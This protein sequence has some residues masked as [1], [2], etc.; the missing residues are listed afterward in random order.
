MPRVA[1]I[2]LLPGHLRSELDRRIIEAGYGGSREHVEWLESQGH[3]FHRQ[4]IETYAAK[5]RDRLQQLADSQNFA[6]AYG[7]SLGDNDSAV[8]RMLNGLA[9]DALFKVMQKLH[10]QCCQ[11]TD[12]SDLWGIIRQLG[13]VTKAL[14][15]TSRSDIAVSKYTAEI[16]DRQAASLAALKL[17]GQELGINA[18][19][20]RRLES[21]WLGL[22]E[23]K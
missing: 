2:D 10:Q 22:F 6:I 11:L 14:S 16:R 8:P 3:K 13:M 4:T 19:Y 9:Q 15:D 20:L 18:E 21:E 5:M 12:E 17:E 7:H 1:K 23:S